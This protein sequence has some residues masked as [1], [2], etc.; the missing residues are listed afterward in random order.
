MAS[1]DTHRRGSPHAPADLAQLERVLLSLVAQAWQRGWQPA[2]VIRQVRRRCSA[3][4]AFVVAFAVAADHH[5]RPPASLHPVWAE[6]IQSLGLPHVAAVR[7]WLSALPAAQQV[8]PWQVGEAARHAVD[9]LTRLGPMP[10]IVPP[11]GEPW[12]S[13]ATSRRSVGNDPVLE[14]VRRLLAQAESTTFPAEAETF[15]AKAHELIARHALDTAMLWEQQ[16]RGDEPTSIRLPIDDPY[17]D[18]KSLLLHVVATSSRC[19]AVF[20]SQLALATVVG[21]ADDVAAAD[22]LFTSLLV[23]AQSALQAESAAAPPGSRVR[24]RGFRSSF[25]LAYAHRVGQRLAEI[26]EAVEAAAD[27]DRPGALLPVLVARSGAIDDV[28]ESMFG[29]LTTS[30]SRTVRDGFGWERGAQAADRAQLSAADLTA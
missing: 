21:F 30:R 10:R 28:V 13:V 16:A 11:P 26:N 27:A 6:Q 20:H 22:L 2:E 1:W 24:S 17:V 29:R 4:A 3:D 18:A 25:W 12:S 15:T 19:R 14:R 7:G 8:P 9:E 5:S 23:Q